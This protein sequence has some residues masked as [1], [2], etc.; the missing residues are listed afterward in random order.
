[1]D[2]ELREQ[3]AHIL[4]EPMAVYH[5]QVGLQYASIDKT[6]ALNIADQILALIHEAGYRKV[7]GTPL[8]LTIEDI[9]RIWEEWPSGKP[10][11]KSFDEWL[12]QAQRDADMKWLKEPKVKGGGK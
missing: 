10:T 2:K 12:C 6:K 8:V 5:P 7:S 3:I 1:M 4:T 9:K 11:A